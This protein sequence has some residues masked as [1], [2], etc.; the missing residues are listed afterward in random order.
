MKRKTV[1][2]V[3]GEWKLIDYVNTECEDRCDA[4]FMATVGSECFED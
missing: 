2:L 1:K 3:N 4:E